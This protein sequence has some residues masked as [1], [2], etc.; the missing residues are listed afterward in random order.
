MAPAMEPKRRHQRFSSVV[1]A[2]TS[3]GRPHSITE[4][5]RGAQGGRLEGRLETA[6]Q[7]VCDPSRFPSTSRGGRYLPVAS[8][9]SGKLD[10]ARTLHLF[11]AA[12]GGRASPA[13]TATSSAGP[14]FL[15]KSAG[16]AAVLFRSCGLCETRLQSL[17][18]VEAKPHERSDDDDR[19]PAGAGSPKHRLR[20]IG[21][22]TASSSFSQEGVFRGF[23]VCLPTRA[24]SGVF[25]ANGSSVRDSAR[26]R[27]RP[28]RP[29]RLFISPPQRHLQRPND[30]P[31]DNASCALGRR[32]DGVKRA[33]KAR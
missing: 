30:R 21:R 13:S 31:K 22:A 18:D 12:V 24:G 1:R 15:G 11:P 19:A 8:T 23:L 14:G 3:A 16:A 17:K 10:D 5:P 25:V 33:R 29:A 2:S 9:A 26:P 32:I 27:E 20:T 7:S 28:K 4:S 6:Q